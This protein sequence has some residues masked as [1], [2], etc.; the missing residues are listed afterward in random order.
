MKVLHWLDEYL[1]AGL[2]ALLLATIVALITTQ[3]FMR[4]VLQ[5]SLSWSEEL[6]LWFFVWF[7]WLATSYAFKRRVHVKVAVLSQVLTPK[8][9]LILSIF[10]QL[11]VV[12][13]LTVLIYQCLILMNMPFVAKQRSVVLGMPIQYFYA[14][15]PFGAALSLW[16]LFQ[17]LFVDFKALRTQTIHVPG[18]LG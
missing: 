4:Y 8:N 11:L 6:T 17:N 18:T 10:T 12:V 15:A 5:N 9:Q 1:E 2:A 3:V 7:I 16:R 13:F 14:S